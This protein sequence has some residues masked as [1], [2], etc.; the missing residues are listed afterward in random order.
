[1]PTYSGYEIE[2]PFHKKTKSFGHLAKYLGLRAAKKIQE[3]Q[4]KKQKPLLIQN[5]GW[6]LINELDEFKYTFWFEYEYQEYMV[7][8]RDFTYNE[9]T[10]R[11]SGTCELYI[12]EE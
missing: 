1:M 4:N 7:I 12:R 3:K 6:V 8:I 2:F 9:D 5:P 10:E 11:V